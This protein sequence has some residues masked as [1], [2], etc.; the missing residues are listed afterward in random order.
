MTPGD[1]DDPQR[2]SDDILAA[3][4]VLGVLPAD[5]RRTAAGRID[6]D[7][8]FARLVDAW[9]ER[10]SPL[11]AGYEDME[12]PAS[13]KAAL[14][15]RLFTP[16]GQPAAPARSGLMQSLAFWRGIAAAAVA[17][18]LLVV[19]LP[20][21]RPPAPPA[22]RLVASLSGEG[23]DVRYLVVYDATAGE[24]GLSH[25]AGGHDAGRDF[26]LWAIEG[27]AP[28]VSLG[29]IPAGTSVRL[30]VAPGHRAM[31]ASG[32]LFAISLEP[33]GGSPTGQPTGP[34]VAAGDLHTI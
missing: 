31:I 32:V 11:N 30:A 19:A 27:G 13:V 23:S 10:L 21:L 34:V 28:P 12:P 5:E 7:P 9:E 26:E 15:A 22:G 3:E 33:A 18:L 4:Y 29:V 2:G 25:V 16:R 8:A 17:A 6:S 20:V 1:D 24:I 14:D